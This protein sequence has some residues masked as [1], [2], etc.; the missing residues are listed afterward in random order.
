MRVEQALSKRALLL[1]NR[2]YRQRQEEL[3]DQLNTLLAQR[4]RELLAL[5]KLFQSQIGQSEAAQHAYSQLRESLAEFTSQLGGLATVVG[6]SGQDPDDSKT[7]CRGLESP[8]S[9]VQNMTQT[10]RLHGSG[11]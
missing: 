3:I 7:D 2:G 10:D 11:K 6:M 1:E 8:P 4:Q 9:G 5:N